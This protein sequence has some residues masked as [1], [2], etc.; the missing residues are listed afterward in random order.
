MRWIPWDYGIR[1][2][3]RSPVRLW[4][5]VLGSAL[6]VLLVL[7]AAAFVRGMDASLVSTGGAR[8]VI[9]LGAGS[10]E[11]FERSEISPT[12]PDQVAASIKGIKSRLGVP[13]VSPEV[14]LDSTIKTD[15]DAATSAQASVRGVKPEAFL[16][17]GQVRIAEGRMPQPG[18]DELLVGSAMAAKLGIAGD[19]LLIG[20]TL[21][22]D[23][24]AW[25]IVGRF[26]APGTVLEAELWVPLSDLQLAARR[27]NLSCVILTLDGD[28]EV[29][30]V[31]VFAKRRT[32]LELVA[33]S[34]RDYYGQLS[35]F[36]KPIQAMVWATAL[37]IAMG[38]LLGGLNTMYA[39]FVSRVRE[40]AMLQTIGFSRRAI[41]ISLM[42]ESVIATAAGSLVAAVIGLTLLS[43]WQVRF[44]MGVFGL[45]VDSSVLL[46][47]LSA[48]LLLGIIGALPPAVRCLRLP[49]TQALK[50]A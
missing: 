16:V 28:T 36:F 17:H 9:L 22:F 21:W 33:I 19:R 13:Y 48:G 23:D 43:G 25:T 7:A 39:A 41:A 31:E 10:E 15:R 35:A 42:Q 1:N 46:Q 4:L 38:G 6:V 5:S 14:Y 45:V 12:V 29:G 26:E 49:I 24:R 50:A 37:L 3:A 8:N 20:K 47:A 27:E 11:S 30:D 18:R 32:D 34:E 44:S 40:F 2:M